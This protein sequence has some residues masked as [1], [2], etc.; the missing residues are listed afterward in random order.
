MN[1]TAIMFQT[2][3]LT[4]K[5]SDRTCGEYLLEFPNKEVGTL[6]SI[7]QWNIMRAVHQMR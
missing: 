6:F 4:V 2:G 5:Q 7:L 1:I 3:Y